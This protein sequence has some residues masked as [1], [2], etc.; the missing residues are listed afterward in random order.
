VLSSA[1]WAG[2][3]PVTLERTGTNDLL[4]LAGGGVLGHPDGPAAGITSIRQAWAAA[5]A[6]VPLDEVDSPELVR[7]LE[8]FGGVVA[9]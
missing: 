1:Q 6:G 3:A 8:H 7:A 2:T 5:V 4:V 9:R